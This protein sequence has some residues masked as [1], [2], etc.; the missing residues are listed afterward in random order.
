MIIKNPKDV[1]CKKIPGY[2]GVKKQIF[3]GPKDGSHEI[4]MRYFSV[5]PGG[6]TPYHQHNFPHL[7][8]VE[9]GSGIVIDADGKEYNLNVGQLVYIDDNEIHGFKNTGKESF[10]ILC[11]VPGRGEK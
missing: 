7:V 3:I 10:D 11:I 2:E 8:K 5:E 1:P 9:K 4:S 6:A